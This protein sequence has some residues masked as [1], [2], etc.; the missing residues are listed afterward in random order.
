MRQLPFPVEYSDKGYQLLGI[1][2]K[3]KNL[4]I[5][6]NW[7]PLTGNLV[8]SRII[9]KCCIPASSNCSPAFSNPNLAYNGIASS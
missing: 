3:L 6:G 7:Q 2:S 8:H 9:L 4:A 5:S 1:P